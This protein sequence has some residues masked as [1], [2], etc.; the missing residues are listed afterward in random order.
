MPLFATALAA[1]TNPTDNFRCPESYATDAER[2]AAVKVFTENFVKQ[3][4]QGT[5]DDLVA[6]RVQLLTAHNCRQTQAN[7]A[8]NLKPEEAQQLNVL[9]QTQSLMLAGRKF[10]RVDEYYDVATRVWSVIFVD[11]PH[12]PDTYANQVVLNFYDWTPRP[13]VESVAAALGEERPGTKNI[14]LFKAPVRPGGEMIYHIISVKQGRTNF[15]YLM[16]VSCY[17]T[18]AVNINFGHRLGDGADLSKTAVE[19]EQWLLS[20]ESQSLRDAVASIRLGAGWHNYL[21]QVK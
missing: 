7:K 17:G 11:D 21:Q 12:H 15:L 8:G 16:S 10:T 20:A 1:Q 2:E 18:S 5:I 19:A 3:H 9:P 14:F 13:T 4:P 6:E